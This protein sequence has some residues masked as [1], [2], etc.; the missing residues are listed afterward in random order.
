MKRASR[1]PD[2]P[3]QPATRVERQIEPPDSIAVE[4]ERL[5]SKRY[6]KQYEREYHGQFVA[7]DVRSGKAYVAPFPEQVLEVA[8]EK[9]PGGMFYLIRV[10]APQAFRVSYASLR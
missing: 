5:Y 6:K 10:G 8:Q 1:A 7:I 3:R 9:C 4:G 2:V